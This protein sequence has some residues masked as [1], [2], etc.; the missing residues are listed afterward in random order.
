MSIDRI[1]VDQISETDLRSLT[2]T[3]VPEGIAMDYKRASYGNSDADTREFLKD[4]SSFANTAGGHLI[5]GIEEAD[6]GVAAKI[7]PLTGLNA[8][9]ELLRLENMMRHGIKPRVPGVRMRALPIETGGFV[10]VIR[11]PRSWNPPHQVSAKNTNRFYV[12]NSAGVHEVSIDELRTLFTFGS[13]IQDRTRTFRR[14]RLAIIADRGTPAVLRETRGKVI[15]HIVPLSAFSTRDQV[16]LSRAKGLSLLPD[17]LSG[18]TSFYNFDGVVHIAFSGDL[19]NGYTQVFR[20]GCIESVNVCLMSVG[21]VDA[22]TISSE[23][24]CRHV[25]DIVPSNIEAL[26]HLEVPTPLV[27]MLTLEVPHGSVLGVDGRSVIVYRPWP[28]RHERLELPEIVIDDYGRE[29]NYRQQMRPALD[30]LW[31]AGGFPNYRHS[32]ADGT[33]RQGDL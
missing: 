30:A 27:V 14:E 25:S 24:L 4:V 2:E 20:N 9:Q 15:L 18:S 13:S 1:N 19:S 11:V 29:L 10:I 6:E 12:R 22:P 17:S 21:M 33:W 26:R 16:D 28:I 5:L 7:T 8:D 31:N 23:W 3:G 32:N